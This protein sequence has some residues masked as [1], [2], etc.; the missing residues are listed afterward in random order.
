MNF[1]YTY[2][3]LFGF[4]LFEPLVIFTNVIFFLLAWYYFVQ[5][6]K[7]Q[8]AYS[9]QM[10]L[11]FVL[12]GI[13]A[14]FG[15]IGHGAHYQLGYPFF[16]GV[17]F[18]MNAFSLI[19]MY[20][21][22]LGPFTYYK[23]GNSLHKIYQLI[24][25]VWIVLVLVF[26]SVLKNFAVIKVHA[27]IVLTYSLVVHWKMF[28]RFRHP[29]SKWV[30]IGILISF[31]PIIVHSLK[32]SVGEW[33]NHKDIAHVLM[34]ISMAVIYKGAVQNAGDIQKGLIPLGPRA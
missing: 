16:N 28:L 30:V 21:C 14:L 3:T 4:I 17:L 10:A 20:Y 24:L 11:F 2:I 1:D 34:I 27:G 13:S 32:L 9:R 23:Q 7:F 25:I 31:L 19:A 29:G 8:N 33:C 15:A 6:K 26:C 22:F 12:L 5:L 18:L